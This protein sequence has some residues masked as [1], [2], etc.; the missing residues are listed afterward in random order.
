MVM[1]ERQDEKRE[2]VAGACVKSYGTC[3]ILGHARQLELAI[4]YHACTNHLRTLRLFLST[5][6]IL[7]SPYLFIVKSLFKTKFLGKF[8]VIASTSSRT[9]NK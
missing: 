8:I 9:M 2:K 4:G 6:T 7:S 3:P 1:V 5:S